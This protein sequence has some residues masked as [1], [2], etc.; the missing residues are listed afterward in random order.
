M[1]DNL[2]KQQQIR[3]SPGKMWVQEGIMTQAGVASN[4]H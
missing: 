3:D 1:I 4:K 2:D